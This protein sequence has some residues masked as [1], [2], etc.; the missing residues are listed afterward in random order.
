MRIVAHFG[1]RPLL[2]ASAQL[3]IVHYA[4]CIISR[5]PQVFEYQRHLFR[6]E[7]VSV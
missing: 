6:C 5:F 7:R 2:P 4:L 1:Y 3:C